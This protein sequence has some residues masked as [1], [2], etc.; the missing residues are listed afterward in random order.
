[1]Q[2]YPRKHYYCVFKK[3]FLKS[4]FFGIWVIGVQYD[5]RFGMDDGHLF[6]KIVRSGLKKCHFDLRFR[7][8]CVL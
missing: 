5:A 6:V 1:M 8:N 7:E 2:N 3:S 4:R